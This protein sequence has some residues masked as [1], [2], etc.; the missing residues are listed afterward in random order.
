MNSCSPN[1]S[2]NKDG[3]RDLTTDNIKKNNDSLVHFINN[4]YYLYQRALKNNNLKAIESFKG[5]DLNQEDIL[6]L[7]QLFGFKNKDEFEDILRHQILL[8]HYIES[9]YDFTESPS[10]LQLNIIQSGIEDSDWSNAQTI[11]G[12]GD[13]MSHYNDCV[14]EAIA[15]DVIMTA[16]CTATDPFAIACGV[17]AAVYTTAEIN[18]CQ[19]DYDDCVDNQQNS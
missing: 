19:L 6:V 4:E 8:G 15:M 2:F 18:D 17:A 16:G 14:T 7:S 12:D 5:K 3:N 13:C 1:D 11:Y 10:K 9:A